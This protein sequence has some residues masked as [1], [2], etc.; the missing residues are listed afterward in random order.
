MPSLH[1]LSYRDYENVYEPAEDTYLLLDCIQYELDQR[2]KMTTTTKQSI[3]ANNTIYCLE[4]GCGSGVVTAFTQQYWNKI[5][6][7]IPSQ[8]I[9]DPVTTGSTQENI[10]SSCCDI[11]L[12]FATDINPRAL[13]VTKQTYQHNCIKRCN[14]G[15]VSTCTTESNV[16]HHKTLSCHLELIQCDLAT[17][18]LPQLSNM[19]DIIIMN[20][21]YVPT[22][23]DEVNQQ[24]SIVAAW[25]GGIDGRR[26][27]DRFIPQL[28]QL[29]H[30]PNGITY[31]VTVDDN[32]PYQLAQYLYTTYGLS[33]K[34]LFRRRAF[35][36]QLTIQKITWGK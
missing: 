23:D 15:D 29:L 24:G 1:H 17:S 21:P 8:D 13:E 25:A 5:Q 9:P 2:R 3:D 6:T 19:C 14:N 31:L 30:R 32:K 7:P 10:V 35:N 20:P 33:M 27:I 26:V 12:N 11:L 28:V 4:V 16:N 18:L 22:P 36:E 34:P